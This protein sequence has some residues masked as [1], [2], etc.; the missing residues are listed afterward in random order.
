VKRDCE[1]LPKVAF[2]P[3]GNTLAMAGDD[4]AA[5][6]HH[7]AT[8]NDVGR[9]A[10]HRRVVHDLAFHP[11]PGKHL[12]ATTDGHGWMVRVWTT[13]PLA[14]RPDAFL[15]HQGFA[16][17][18]AFSPEGRLLATASEDRMVQVWDATTWKRVDFWRDQTG[19]PQCLAFCP[20]DGRLIAWGGSDS[21]VKL[22]LRESQEVVI[23]RGHTDSVL[24][25]AFSL[26]GR[27]IASVSNDGTARIWETP[28]FR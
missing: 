11:D 16:S 7:P 14:T 1:W 12:L 3:D 10:G 26:D 18:V 5:V 22:W 2:S 25:L 8:E 23:L 28:S 6:L 24:G 19:A 15:R 27:W 21:T 9:L 17:A 13:K 4:G 20:T